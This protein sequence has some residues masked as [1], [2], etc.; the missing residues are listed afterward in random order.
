MT[1]TIC[2]HSHRARFGVTL[3]EALIAIAILA[4]LVGMVAPAVSRQITHSRVNEAAQAIA[5]DL[6]SALSLAGRQRRPVRVTVDPAQR[7]LL[8]VD[9]ASG[10]VITRR[11]YGAMSDYQVGALSA[12]PASID[13]LPH[14]VTTS[15]ATITVSSGTYS[16]QVTVTRG[17]VVRVQP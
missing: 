6:E 10:Q 8:T 4:I 12:S 3:I 1:T 13:I 5:S 7:A 15:A 2:S 11:A 17:G 9:R 14:G 16:R